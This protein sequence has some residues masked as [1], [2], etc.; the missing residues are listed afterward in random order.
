M[1]TINVNVNKL[2][3]PDRVTGKSIIDVKHVGK[4]DS[5][6]VHYDDHDVILLGVDT[7]EKK[8]LYFASVAK[9]PN[10]ERQKTWTVSDEYFCEA[11]LEPEPYK[12]KRPERIEVADDAY[13]ILREHALLPLVKYLRRVF[14]DEEN[15]VLKTLNVLYAMDPME[16]K[17]NPKEP[18]LE[19]TVAPEEK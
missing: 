13:I 7:E 4:I 12:G 8:V 17:K 10:L 3:R 18:E 11:E 19:M 15:E 6:Y 5:F 1:P 9:M 14:A 2:Y 16:I